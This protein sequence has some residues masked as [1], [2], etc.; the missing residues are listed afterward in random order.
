MNG[1]Y[2]EEEGKM[3]PKIKK[4]KTLK[5]I[6]EYEKFEANCQMIKEM[7]KEQRSSVSRHVMHRHNTIMA[8]KYRRSEEKRV[9][10]RR[11]HSHTDQASKSL[12]TEERDSFSM[13]V[14]PDVEEDISL[15]DKIQLWRNKGGNTMSRG[16]IRASSLPALAEEE[17]DG[18][19]ISM[20]SKRR[21]KSID[22]YNMS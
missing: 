11:A 6:Q 16:W 7:E 20:K 10:L 17:E 8:D 3:P 18:E 12:T 1:E 15:D 2:T 5:R 13:P 4:M 19:T 14:L 21:S 22:S 9:K